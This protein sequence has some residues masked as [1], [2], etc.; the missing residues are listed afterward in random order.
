M[1]T[2]S[3]TAEHAARPD[4]AEGGTEASACQAATRAR[5]APTPRRSVIITG[6]TSSDAG[7]RQRGDQRQDPDR[8]RRAC[9]PV[10]VD[11]AT[12]ATSSGPPVRE[13]PRHARAAAA[14]HHA[15]HARR[16]CVGSPPIW[17]AHEVRGGVGA[18]QVSRERLQR[19]REQGEAGLDADVAAVAE[20]AVDR[21]ELVEREHGE[22]Q[23][24]RRP[25]AP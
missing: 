22:Q 21:V 8:G 11:H 13:H 24:E 12:S 10:G 23:A 14:A 7:A 3:S 17:Y 6:V 5:C 15:T 16:R 18:D 20:E 4:E 9:W 2:N 1:K 25:S 19:D